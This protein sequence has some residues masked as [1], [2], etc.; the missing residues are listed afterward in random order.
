M[1]HALLDR[2]SEHVSG[3]GA[4]WILGLNT[5]LLIPLIFAVF[6]YPWEVLV[7]VGAA[8]ALTV[9]ALVVSRLVRV[10]LHRHA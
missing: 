8:F 3:E 5:I 6:F 10:R 1:I 4:W 2:V 7:G 9:V